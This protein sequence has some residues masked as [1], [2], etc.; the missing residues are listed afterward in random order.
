MP[1]FLKDGQSVSQHD[2]VRSVQGLL[3]VCSECSPLSTW[4]PVGKRIV[5][6]QH[7]S[8]KML[9]EHKRMDKMRQAALSLDVQS[10]EHNRSPSSPSLSS[11]GK[12][13]QNDPQDSQTP[14]RRRLG[15]DTARI[16]S[17]LDEIEADFNRKK[18]SGNEK[19]RP[20]L[21]FTH[22]PTLSSIPIMLQPPQTAIEI[23]SGRFALDHR[24]QENADILAYEVWLMEHTLAIERIGKIK[25]RT[26]RQRAQALSCD[27]GEELDKVECRK[28]DVWERQRIETANAPKL[29]SKVR[30]SV[31]D[32]GA[33]MHPSQ[34][35]SFTLTI[36]DQTSTWQAGLRA[37]EPSP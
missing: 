19:Y 6:G 36:Q 10:A 20:D 7:L 22:P 16:K 13:S 30:S 11:D 35:S 29:G 37:L 17:V 4:D 15:D 27:F 12:H 2:P 24:A 28:M 9:K 18:T 25:A 23:N 26:L 34:I 32:C 5:H 8:E 14:P 21:V 3:C 31:I 1:P 33:Y